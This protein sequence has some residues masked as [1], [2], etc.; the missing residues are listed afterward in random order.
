M[1]IKGIIFD[2][3]GVIVDN[4]SFHVSAWEKFITAH[5][6][7]LTADEFSLHFNG[8]TTSQALRYLF[9]EIT[10]ED[11][12]GFKEEKESL[13]RQLF[14]PHIKETEGLTDFLKSLKAQGFLTAVAT[15]AARLKRLPC[16]AFLRPSRPP[17][18]GR[19]DCAP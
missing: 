15:A 12:D 8:R 2:M 11:L 6:R 13:Y 16:P 3:D 4:H 14:R 7:Q 9:P 5:N 1:P 17:R 18:P 10:A 19:P